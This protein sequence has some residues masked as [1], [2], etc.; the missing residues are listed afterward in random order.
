MLVQLTRHLLS[1]REPLRFLVAALVTVP[2]ASGMAVG[3]AYAMGGLFE[4]VLGTSVAQPAFLF[5]FCAGGYGTIAAG[6]RA[7]QAVWPARHR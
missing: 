3:A 7:L 1:Q 6:D 4:P 2:L 5:G